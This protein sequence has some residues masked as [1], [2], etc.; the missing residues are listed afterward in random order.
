MMNVIAFV[1]AHQVVLAALG[2][3]VI[4][5]AMALSPSLAGNGILHQL[6]VLLQG[7]PPAA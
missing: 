6:L 4:D 2:V 3:A 1:Q 7:K 5:L